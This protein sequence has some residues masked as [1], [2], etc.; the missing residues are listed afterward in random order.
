MAQL[1]RKILPIVPLR[2]KPYDDDEDDKNN[3]EYSFAIEYSG[4]PISSDI[5]LASPI[6]VDQIPMAVTVA[7]PSLLSDRSLPV[8][9][10]IVKS[11]PVDRRRLK[12]PELSSEP[13]LHSNSFTNSGVSLTVP[14]VSCESQSLVDSSG[15]VGCAIGDYS[16]P[17]S[18]NGVRNSSKFRSPDAQDNSSNGIRSSVKLHSLDCHDNSCVILKLSDGSEEG[19]D[20]GLQNG[21][22]PA[23]SD[24]TDSG[25]SS[26]EHTS[27]FFSRKEGYFGDEET[28]SNVRGSSVVISDDPETSDIVHEESD[29]SESVHVR[30]KA[31]RYGKKSSCCQCLQE[32]QSLEMEVCI[33]CDAMYCCNCVVRA[34]GSTPEG[35]KCVSC[36]D[37]RLHGCMPMSSNGIG[38]SGKSNSLN[39]HDN[40]PANN[41]LPDNRND[42]ANAGFHDYMNPANSESTESDVSSHSVSS[43]VFSCKEEGFNKEET[44]GHVRKPSVVTFR[45]PDPS[46]AVYEE[47]DYLEVE[48]IHERPKAV[49]PGKKGSCYRCLK[50]NRFTEKEVCIVCGAKYCSNCVLR[51]MGSMPEGRKC[52]T[53]IGFSMDDSKRRN[54]GKCSRMLKRLLTETEVKQIM[55]S[56][57]SCKANQLPPERV[58]VNGEHLSQKELVIL[59]SCPNPPKKL[60]P[61]TYWYDKVLGFWGKEGHRPCQI[62]SPQLNVGG[63]I[64]KNASNGNTNVMINNR[65][66]TRRELWLLKLAGVQC[67]G[68]PH[69]WVSADGSYTEEGMKNVKGRIWDKSTIKL[70]CA[71]LSLPTPPDSENPCGNEVNGVNQCEQQRPINLLLLGEHKSGTSTIYKQAK[72][73][74]KVPFSEEE[75]QNIKFMIQSNLY[76]Y[77]GILLEGRERF[78]AES[79]FGKG[80]RQV[81]DEPGPSGQID[82]KMMYSISPRLKSF[83]DWL[84]KVMAS[85]NLEAIFPAATREYAPFIEEL[86]RD[87]GFQATYNRR[88]E[89][90]MLPRHA[91]YFLER[92]VEISKT[93]Y[94]PSDMDILYAEEITSTN[95]LLSMLFS[96]PEQTQENSISDSS[97][98]NDPLL[99]Y[100][101]IRVHPRSLGENCKW[102]QMFEDA[103]MVL[104]CVSLTAYDEYFEDSKGF[105]TNKMLA[106]RQ[107]FQ[108][109]V[110][111]PTFNQKNFLLILNKYDM[112]EEKIEEVP[113]SRCE[114]FEDFNPV[115]S[116]NHHSTSRRTSNTPLA[117]SAAHYIAVKFKRL[118]DSLTGR[119]L[120]VSVV[121][122]LE[123][124]TVDEALKYAKEILKWEEEE[125]VYTNIESTDYEASSSS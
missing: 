125:P 107:L 41:E 1:L 97:D 113:L 37:S 98:Q 121:T 100:Q 85:G 103:D 55:R 65:V 45:D 76:F 8:I 53:C 10:P 12:E 60:N 112:L 14:N 27:K 102:L 110:I 52:V 23:N 44:P 62:I 58:F 50:G 59:L 51:A 114:W 109:I 89:L 83:S 57:I 49:R 28:P 95:G 72:L 36:V 101:L 116:H 87:A 40:M 20:A 81:I 38:S 93:G 54:L 47:S 74:F 94:E 124:E 25:L 39:C 22:N 122:A 3:A 82:D 70:L 42:G 118:F 73:L 4:P 5:P 68:Q 78:E 108:N 18:V 111:H 19:A 84:L 79:L 17:K 2:S 117:V 30:A 46:D 6:V 61:G 43:E 105:L 91:T 104:F 99:S 119:K 56:E 29:N 24:S 9:Q 71:F 75:R 15:D 7:S 106:S 11:T 86:W 88:N 63:Q 32:Y 123:P 34:M 120:F 80:K 26:H 64:M 96:L 66:I 92:A 33:V 35:R 13:T 115:I 21:I 90:D 67:E 48:S 16:Q 69:F 31:E 77:I